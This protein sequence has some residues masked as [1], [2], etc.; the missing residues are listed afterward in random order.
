[1]RQ[2]TLRF[3]KGIN[4][5]IDPF[6]AEPNRIFGLKNARIHD[7]GDTFSIS[8]IKGYLKKDV[9]ELGVKRVLDLAF[10]SNRDLAVFYTTNT[11]ESKIKIFDVESDY[12]NPTVIETFTIADESY[13]KGE[14]LLHDTTLFITPI[15]KMIN[16]IENTYYLNDYV[17]SVPR[18]Q[19]VTLS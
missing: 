14:L 10:T 12:E 11:P 15:N 16:F 7:R 6:K 18:I 17:P 3:Q 8:R 1:M 9:L 2:T 5:R 4:E 13:K 19:N